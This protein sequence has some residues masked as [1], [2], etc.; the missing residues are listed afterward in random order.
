MAST[1]DRT[2]E[3]IVGNIRGPL[4]VLLGAVFCVLLIACANVANLLL[5]SGLSRRRELAIRLALG[6]GQ[7]DVARQ[8]TFEALLLSL[9]GGALGLLLAIWRPRV[10]RARWELAAARHAPSMSTPAS[11]RSRPASRLLVG[12]SLRSLAAAR[13][14]V[15]TLTAAMREGDI[16][17]RRAAPDF[18]NGLVV[19]EIAMAFALL[20][21]AGLL[22]KNLVLLEQPRC[23]NHHGSRHRV[24]LLTV[25]PR[26]KRSAAVARSTELYERLKQLGGVASVGMTSHL[27]MYRLRQ[28]RRDDP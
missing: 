2:C 18:G 12:D 20:V 21:G 4:Q 26:Y 11:L 27:P 7:R 25:G 22:V 23:R 6:A 17:H 28:Q 24:R 19:A 10:R 9:A 16:A 8:L 3:A 15:S 1:C 13:L 5:A 14:R